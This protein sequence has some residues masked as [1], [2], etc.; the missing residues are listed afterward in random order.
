[1]YQPKQ[2]RLDYSLMSTSAST[3]TRR[4]LWGSIPRFLTLQACTRQ[5]TLD[6]TRT[7]LTT[8][9][10]D[11]EAI[12]G[13]LQPLRVSL[14]APQ[15]RSRPGNISAYPGLACLAFRPGTSIDT[16]QINRSPSPL[17][18]RELSKPR[19]NLSRPRVND[20]LVVSIELCSE[21]QRFSQFALSSICPT[22]KIATREHYAEKGPVVCVAL[23]KH[24][25]A[26][27]HALVVAEEAAPDPGQFQPEHLAQYDDFGG[28]LYPPSESS[29]TCKCSTSC[30][31]K[32]IAV[33]FVSTSS[34]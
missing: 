13:I 26:A 22:V 23:P 9:V 3:N 32:R 12:L 7:P 33:R 20:A 5:L 4:T 24:H 14:F 34:G 30:T 1:M 11:Y 15:S 27:S 8:R 28:G 29:D 21:V 16:I 31:A 2:Q 6:K 25:E 17:R 19:L 10:M 18:C